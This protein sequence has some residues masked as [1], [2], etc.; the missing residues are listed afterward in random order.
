MC[1]A[2]ALTVTRLK[3]VREGPI[4]LG[5]LKPGQWRELTAAELAA[6]YETE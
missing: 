1:E 4:S 5:D 3:R 6:L 2:A